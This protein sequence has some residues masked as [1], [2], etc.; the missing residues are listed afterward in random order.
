MLLR[1]LPALRM[2]MP[3]L[4]GVTST[5][6][7]TIDRVADTIPVSVARAPSSRKEVVAP[8]PWAIPSDGVMKLISTIR[9]GP[10]PMGY[11]LAPDL[12]RL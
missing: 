3:F 5:F 8:G 10:A 9:P 6:W 12:V 4:I 11:A 1:G 7:G 2:K